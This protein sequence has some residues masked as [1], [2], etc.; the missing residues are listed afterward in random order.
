MSYGSPSMGDF[1]IAFLS[2]TRNT[3]RFHEI[4][5][6]LEHKRYKEGSLRVSMSR[7]HKHGLVANSPGGWALTKIG[8]RYHND[9][10]AFSYI[11]SP[12][13]KSSEPKLIISFDVPQ[14]HKRARNWLRN[15]LK[16]FGYKMIHQSLW[17]G[18]GPLPKTFHKRLQ[19]LGVRK[20]I[21]I[22]SIRKKVLS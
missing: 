3:K 21:K 22:F 11:T 6:E 16:I 10:H 14:T 4:L 20:S 2:S 13:K 1:L 7:L 12:F 18:P 17:L 9:F 5:R 15:Q 8:K 19:I